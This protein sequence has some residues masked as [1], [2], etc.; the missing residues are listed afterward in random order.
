MKKSLLFILFSFLTLNVFSQTFDS[1]VVINGL[2]KNKN[3]MSTNENLR[4]NILG[5]LRLPVFVR[6][7]A[8]QFTFTQVENTSGNWKLTQPFTVGYSY[9]C[10]FANATL[11]Q[12]SSMTVENHFFFG[13]GASFGVK[14]DLSSIG[15]TTNCL[16]VGVI[17]G[18]SKFGVFSGYDFV[19]QKPMVG[20]AVNMLNFPLLQKTTRFSVRHN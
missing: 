14:T 11:H 13:V 9:I 8:V 16:P 5:D 2:K 6:T 4:T 15:G 7:P 3:L 17:F 12:D 20:I 10:T 19:G 1:N 18:Y